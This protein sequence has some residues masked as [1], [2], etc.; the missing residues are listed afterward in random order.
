MTTPKTKPPTD[1]VHTLRALTVSS[2]GKFAD[3]LRE[4]GCEVSA[5]PR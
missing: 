4:D 3:A 1:H 5:R 2:I